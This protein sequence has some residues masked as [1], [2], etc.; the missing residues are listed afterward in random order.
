MERL[1]FAELVKQNKDVFKDI[2]RSDKDTLAC[3]MKLTPETSKLMHG[4]NCS[5]S[6]KRKLATMFGKFLNFNPLASENKQREVE[7][8]KQT[9]VERE[10]LEHGTLLLHKTAHSEYATLNN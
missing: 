1:L 10:T 2:L 8:T 5:Y 4:S 3:V 9:L 6:S 7:K